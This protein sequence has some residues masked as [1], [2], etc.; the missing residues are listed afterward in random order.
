MNSWISVKDKLP[1]KNGNYLVTTKY[2][3]LRIL[4]YAKDLYK[5]HEYDFFDK[6]GKDGWYDYDSEWGYV[7]YED[8]IIAWM[9]LPKPYEPQE[10]EE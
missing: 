8:C 10:S 7:S 9:P 2:N 4:S 5:V 6:K 1:D 3:S